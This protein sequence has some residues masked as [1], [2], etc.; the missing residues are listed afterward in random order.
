MWKYPGNC[1]SI[2][3]KGYCLTFKGFK[4]IWETQFENR[5]FYVCVY[6][7]VCIFLLVREKELSRAE[8]GMGGSFCASGKRSTLNLSKWVWH[9]P[10][11]C[12][13]LMSRQQ[14]FPFSEKCLHTTARQH[15]IHA[16]TGLWSS[17]ISLQ[18]LWN[19]FYFKYF[20][21]DFKFT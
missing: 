16:H 20:K 10:I 7:C 19:T 5:Y 3:A 13:V 21:I 11:I 6:L 12:C 18:I 1:E 8:A 4:G 9:V 15:M 17:H 14:R 2:K